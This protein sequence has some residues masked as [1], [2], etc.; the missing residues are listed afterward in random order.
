MCFQL[1]YNKRLLVI[2]TDFS[3]ISRRKIRNL[4][5]KKNFTTRHIHFEPLI[6]KDLRLKRSYTRTIQRIKVFLRY[7]ITEYPRRRRN[8]EIFVLSYFCWKRMNFCFNEVEMINLHIPFISPICFRSLFVTYFPCI[9]I[10]NDNIR[11]QISI[12]SHRCIKR[13]IISSYVRI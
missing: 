10:A 1:I 5:Y 7:P 9:Q 3:R 11:R 12:Q 2:H 8:I 4:L 13:V 6:F